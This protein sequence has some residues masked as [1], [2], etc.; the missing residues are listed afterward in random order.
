MQ[1]FACVAWTSV[2]IRQLLFSVDAKTKAFT[3]RTYI[4]NTKY[5]SY[6]FE[7]FECVQFVFS[8]LSTRVTCVFVG[9]LAKYLL[10]MMATCIHFDR[11]RVF[12]NSHVSHILLPIFLDRGVLESRIVYRV[13]LWTI[14]N[15]QH[16][17]LYIIK[18]KN[19]CMLQSVERH[20]S[21]LKVNS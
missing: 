13:V 6:L 7:Y 5:I 4:I 14:K 3:N 12:V 2:T 20:Y 17:W 11:K 19:G 18:K 15:L 1:T 10:L 9:C 8:R 21:T 16:G